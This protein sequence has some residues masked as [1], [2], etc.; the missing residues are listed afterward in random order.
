MGILLR[1]ESRKCNEFT[2]RLAAGPC[3]KSV[4]ISDGSFLHSQETA[5][6]CAP[7]PSAWEWERL[8]LSIKELRERSQ[9]YIYQPGEAQSHGAARQEPRVGQ[10]RT[11]PEPT[12]GGNLLEAPAQKDFLAQRT[13]T[14]S[15]TAMPGQGLLKV[16]SAS[17]SFGKTNRLWNQ[18]SG[19]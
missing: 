12:R 6:P 4:W 13:H 11:G 19:C 1:K 18:K 8:D 3:T 17:P 16:V 10:G 14:R 2:S 9:Q 5:A 15:S 7:S